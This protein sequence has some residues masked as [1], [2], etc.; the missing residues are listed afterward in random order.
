MPINQDFEGSVTLTTGYEV[1]FDKDDMTRTM[2]HLSLAIVGELS[3]AHLFQ[4]ET[5]SSEA[6]QRAL[7]E[8]INHIMTTEVP[9][10]QTASQLMSNM[11]YW[12]LTDRFFA[13]MAASIHMEGPIRERFLKRDWSLITNPDGTNGDGQ[14]GGGDSN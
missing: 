3:N 9:D 14:K 1:K 5:P 11:L 2:N 6:F 12:H 7:F 13:D 10:E 4:T 8:E